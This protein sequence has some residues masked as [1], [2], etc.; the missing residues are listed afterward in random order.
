MNGPNGDWKF[1][2][3]TLVATLGLKLNY[4]DDFFT[5]TKSNTHNSLHVYFI[6]NI[7]QSVVRDS[8]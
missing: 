6:K 7:Y 8:G 1:Q 2:E 3:R 5:N 4:F